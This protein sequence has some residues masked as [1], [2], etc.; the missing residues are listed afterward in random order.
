MIKKNLT[1]SIILLFIV[2]L[3]KIF[4]VKYGEEYHT[5]FYPKLN[6]YLKNISLISKLS[7]GDIIYLLLGITILS[8]IL[9]KIRRK[10][11]K[12]LSFYIVNTSLSFFIIFQ[13]FWGLNNYKQS[14]YQSI[15]IEKGYSDDELYTFLDKK[16]NDINQLHLL[17]TQEEKP[18]VIPND[19]NSFNNEAFKLYKEVWFLKEYKVDYL[20]PVKNSMFSFLLSKS[21][22]SGYFNPFTHENQI[23]YQIPTI[24]KPVTVVHEMSHQLGI[25]SETEANF[26]AYYTLSKSENLRYRYAAELNAL[27]Y[28]LNEVYKIN[29]E[30]FYAF[31]SKLNI[32]VLTNINETKEFWKKNKNFSSNIFKPMYGLF[33]KANNQKEGIRSYNRMVDLLI[34]YN[35]KYEY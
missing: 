21:G 16:I 3:I 4:L 32:G 27:R 13:L 7:I 10:Q 9:I 1:F 20:T 5:Y 25:A 23:N 26:I 31:N 14:L 15:K 35:K 33:L 30:K 18:V 11:F 17:I 12:R 8:T 2:A 6:Y 24:M 29:E 34:N 28:L 22:F 19:M